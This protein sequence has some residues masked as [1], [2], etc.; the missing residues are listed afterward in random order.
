MIGTLEGSKSTCVGSG[1][2]SIQSEAQT[3]I[4][5]TALATSHIGIG[6][7]TSDKVYFLF[8]MDMDARKRE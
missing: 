2:T 6:P 5:S 8:Q 7:P 4:G 3:L 1:G